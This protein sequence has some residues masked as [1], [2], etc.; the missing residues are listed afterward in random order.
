MRLYVGF[1]AF[2]TYID[3]A[4]VGRLRA[5]IGEKV[6]EWQESGK[7]ETGGIFSGNRKGFA[8]LNVASE[9][10]A[11]LLLGDIADF[12]VVETYPLVSFETLGKFFA[13]QPPN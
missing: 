3:P 2:Q 9:E 11:F 10:E 12:A 4:D 6:Q 8:V 7:F 5:K 1:T 13:E